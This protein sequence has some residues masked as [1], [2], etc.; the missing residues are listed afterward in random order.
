MRL[1]AVRVAPPARPQDHV[2]GPV[3]GPHRSGGVG[4][5][6]STDG[7]RY[8]VARWATPVSPH[9]TSR[10]PATSAASSGRP[11]RPDRSAVPSSPASST[12]R[13]AR[14]PSPG[15]P[16]TTTRSPRPRSAAATAANRPA[17]QRRAGYAAPGWTT[18][19]PGA[20]ERAAGAGR[21]RSAG[22]AAK[23]YA[24][25]RRHQRATSCSPGSQA[26]PPVWPASGQAKASSRPG[27]SRARSR[28]L[29][30]PLPC[31][32][33]AVPTGPASGNEASPRSAG[34]T[35]STAPEARARG[36]SAAGAASAIR[37]P[38]SPRRRARSA[39]TPVS[40][41]P[42]PRARS[43]RT[44]RDAAAR[45]A[46][47]R[48]AAARGAAVTAT[49][50]PARG[51]RPAPA[52]RTRGAGTARTPRP[53]PRRGGCSARRPVPA[54]TART[55]RRRTRCPCRPARSW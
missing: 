52:P 42:R 33:T 43:T 51:T 45:G 13:R 46:T 47:V 55:G 3:G 44:W 11:V 21:P 12:T 48:G 5:N 35:S 8:A 38:G 10:A 15:P 6:S 19:A 16:V 1:A 41:S 31:R 4:P 7:V 50:A 22:S 40:R 24:D 39:G 26:G 53:S 18:T 17:G 27:E 54:C 32:L 49:T 29:R 9:T 37:A 28:W 36:P 2:L 14:R 34:R 23:P 25:T 20:G 30:G